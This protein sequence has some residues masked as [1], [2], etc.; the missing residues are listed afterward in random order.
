MSDLI[1][2]EDFEVGA[3]AD[4]GTRAVVRDEV[5]AFARDFDP[6][7]FHVDDAAAKASMFGGLIASGWHTCAMVM[8]LMVDSQLSRTASL[9]SPGVDSLRWLQPVR[10]DDTIRARVTVLD[11]RRSASRP[12]LG[13]VR[14]RWEVENQRGEPVL[15]MES[16]GMIAVRDPGAPL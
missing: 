9:G 2:Y 16:T 1:H 11:K 13:L 15:T 8:R 6:Q 12:T 10:P 5:I 4:L 7:P 14:F 3:V